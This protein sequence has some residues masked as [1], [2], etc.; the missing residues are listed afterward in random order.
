MKKD[1][2]IPVARNVHIVAV[3]EWD[4][5]FTARQW[6]IYLVN[7]REDTIEG[8]L[9]M[10]RGNNKDQK[11]SVLRHGLGTME[12]KTAA[13]VEFISEAV[14]A[15]TNE[16]LVTFFAEGKLFERN[17]TFQAHSIS[18]KNVKPVAILDSEGVFGI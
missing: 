11:T 15:F 5:E 17:V 8:V 14:L 1:I 9:V 18:E 7:D 16:Y 6:N 10:S 3:R 2:D 12:A 4:K 13:K